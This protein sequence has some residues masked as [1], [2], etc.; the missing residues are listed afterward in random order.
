M[1][2][3]YTILLLLLLSSLTNC[4]QTKTNGDYLLSF[5]DTVNGGYGYKNQMGKVVIAPGKY[6]IVFTDTFRTFAV[7]AINDKGMVAI[8]R[9]ENILY[10]VFVFDNGPDYPSDGLFRITANDKIGFADAITGQIA[11]AP[12]F[13][14]A[15]P[16][17]NGFAEV[18]TQ[19]KTTTD[20][21]HQSWQSDHWYFIDKTGKKAAKPLKSKN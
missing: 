5:N 6:P 15:Y 10:K 1:V 16:F 14:C 20:G 11:I 12:Q 3:T 13:S 21:E 2:K 8:D 19:C 18:S 9:Q 7:V 4:S 17:E